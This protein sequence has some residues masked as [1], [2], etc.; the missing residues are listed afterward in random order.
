LSIFIAGFSIAYMHILPYKIGWIGKWFRFGERFK[1]RFF[2][3]PVF[4]CEICCAGQLALW[5]FV[6]LCIFHY[7]LSLF[8]IPIGI[9]FIGAT[10]FFTHIFYTA[11]GKRG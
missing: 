11:Y 2:Y 5:S 7:D 6:G 8:L 4:F 3:E 10:I 1:N 9:L